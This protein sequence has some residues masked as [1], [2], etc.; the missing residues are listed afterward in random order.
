MAF[1][2]LFEIIGAQR[3]AASVDAPGIG[4][5]RHYAHGHAGHPV[6]CGQQR[7]GRGFICHTPLRNHAVHEGLHTFD[8]FGLV[9]DGPVTGTP[10]DCEVS[11]RG[12]FG[13]L[14]NSGIG[15]RSG[16]RIG[17]A[18]GKRAGNQRSQTDPVARMRHRVGGRDPSEQ[19]RQLAPGVFGE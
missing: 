7:M 12:H 15:G 9:R 3:A 11:L 8:G 1:G 19:R 17:L 10:I 5:M 14:E 4:H 13:F 2:R 18:A 16:S 6:G